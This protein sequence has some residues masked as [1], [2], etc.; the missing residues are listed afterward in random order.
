MPETCVIFGA[1][2]YAGAKPVI[3]EGDFV[4]AADGGLAVTEKFGIKPD[5]ILGDFDSLG[6]VPDAAGIEIFP[7]KKDYTD[8]YIAV[9]EGLSR[10]C[11]TFVLYGTIG[12]RSDHTFANIQTLAMLS[13]LGKMAFAIGNDEIV[14]VL[15]SKDRAFCGKIPGMNGKAVKISRPMNSVIM[16]TG[17]KTTF[18]VFSLSD[19]STSVTEKGTEYLLD[20]HS[21]TNLFPLGI[22]NTFLKE[23]SV[24][25]KSGVLCVIVEKDRFDRNDFVFGKD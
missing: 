17:L 13:A 1:L 14:F 23:C 10:N 12:G 25:V 20:D 19:V 9:T 15:T 21:L 5:L 4:I 24:S 6:Y 8:S 2:D 22:S 7:T 16:K 18:S 11:D 3:K